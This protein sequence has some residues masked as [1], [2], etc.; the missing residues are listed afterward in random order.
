MHMRAFLQGARVAVAAHSGGRGQPQE[1]VEAQ[2]ECSKRSSRCLA[3]CSP[4]SKMAGTLQDFCEQL[5][6]YL[7]LLSDAA[8]GCPS[9]TS[10]RQSWR[11]RSG[12]E[13]RMAAAG[14]HARPLS[15][16]QPSSSSLTSSAPLRLV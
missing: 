8:A 16:S 12:I 9:G 6:C 7:S 14:L 2:Q 1:L 3:A 15:S 11:R 4:S 10:L 5:I 13:R